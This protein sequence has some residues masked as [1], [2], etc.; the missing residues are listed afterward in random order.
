MGL[1]FSRVGSDPYYANYEKALT[2]I[3]EE[4][5]RE[6]VSV[7]GFG[8]ACIGQAIPPCRRAAAEAASREPVDT[9]L[10]LFESRKQVCN[11]SDA[12]CRHDRLRGLG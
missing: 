12:W 10:R 1:R 3:Q 8:A 7:A 11:A 6:D 5:K 9:V 2:R 4:V